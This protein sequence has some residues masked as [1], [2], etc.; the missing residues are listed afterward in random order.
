M[1]R[2]AGQHRIAGTVAPAIGRDILIDAQA[3]HHVE[4]FV[5]Q[6]VDHARCA[7][8]VVGRIA[9][10]EHIDVGV[11]IGKHALDDLALALP[12]L[13]AHMRARLA[14][15]INGAIRGVVIVNVNL[16][17][18]QAAAEIRHHLADRGFLIV[19]GHQ[20]GY[21]RRRGLGCW[22]LL[23]GRTDPGLWRDWPDRRANPLAL[24][25]AARHAERVDG[26]DRARRSCMVLK[27]EFRRTI[28]AVR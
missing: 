24:V 19:A 22:A 2:K 10:D 17:V 16:R 6:P 18:R 23:A 9:I 1:A 13:A 26:S 21:A 27:A 5:H 7:R 14:G 15:N 20:H 11:D 25:D 28:K 12:A 8:C 3:D 4:M